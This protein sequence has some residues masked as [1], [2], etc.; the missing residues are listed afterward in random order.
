MKVF[1]TGGSGFL[2]QEV[3]RQLLAAGV[4]VR[5]MVRSRRTRL[6]EGAEGIETGFAPSDPGMPL[7]QALSGTDAVLHLAGKVSRDPIDAAEMHFIHVEATRALLGAME[8]SKVRRLVLASTSG[9]IACSKQPRVADETDDAAIEV[10]GR[11]PYYM[12]KRLQEQEVLRWCA[13]GRVEGIVLNPT[14][15]LGPGDDRLS[16]TADVHR[17]LSGRFPAITEGTVAFV[18]VR[19]AA[20]AFVAALTRGRSRERYLLNGAN[21]SVR[22]FVERVALAGNVAMP[23]LKLSERW[24]V[25][26]A[27]VVE[28][29]AQAVDRAPPIDATS[30]EMGCHHWGCKADKASQELGFRARDPQHTVADTVRDLER[31]GLFRRR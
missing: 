4:G 31:R 24:A 1:V 10:I 15:I 8:A 3:I 19:D 18:D 17:I 25:L 11:W 28:G 27:K 13:A 14:L 2:G 22:S 21:M 12:S 26:G 16:S 6:P 20:S 9:V 30:V 23:K 29:L 5:A 7:A